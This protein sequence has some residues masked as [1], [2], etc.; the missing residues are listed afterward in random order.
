[1]ANHV[2]ESLLEFFMFL[3]VFRKLSLGAEFSQRKL[4]KDAQEHKKL[5]ERFI[6]M[7]SHEIR[8]PLSDR[9]SPLTR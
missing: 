6:D 1:M 3:R 4:A 8:N 9:W 7:I 2:D 5:Q